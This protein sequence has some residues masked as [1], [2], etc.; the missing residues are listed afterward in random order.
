MCMDYG[1]PFGLVTLWLCYKSEII[2][3]F[4]GLIIVI[5]LSVTAIVMCKRRR[6]ESM[7][8]L[9][10]LISGRVKS[11]PSISIDEIENKWD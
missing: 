9:G 1:D 7:K 11:I 4:V 3:M 8:T 6:K 10:K 2:L 5:G